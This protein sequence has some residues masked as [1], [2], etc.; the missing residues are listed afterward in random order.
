MEQIQE[1]NAFKGSLDNLNKDNLIKYKN[2]LWQR[3]SEVKA[4][5][6]FKDEMEALQ[7]A[8]H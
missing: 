5:I 6:Q 2:Y 4:I 8:R 7:N 1:L 3:F